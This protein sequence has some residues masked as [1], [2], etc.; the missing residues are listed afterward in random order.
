MKPL[1]YMV[2]FLSG[3]SE[4]MGFVG[5][6]DSAGFVKRTLER[7]PRAPFWHA[8]AVLPVGLAVVGD[9]VVVVRCASSSE[10]EGGGGG[11]GVRWV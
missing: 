3:A 11:V 1:Q 7:S 2:C 5:V 9:M 6:V 4:R 8:E 10:K